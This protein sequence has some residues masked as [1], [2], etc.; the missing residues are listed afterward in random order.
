LFSSLF[1][2]EP[3]RSLHLCVN[4]LFSL[5]PLCS[6]LCDLCVTVPLRLLAFSFNFRL[7]TTLPTSDLLLPDCWSLTVDSPLT[8][9]RDLKAYPPQKSLS[10]HFSPPDAP[11]PRHLPPPTSALPPAPFPPPPSPSR[12]LFHSPAPQFP[13]PHF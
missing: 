4:F 10:S 3:R 2:C 13:L 5:C 7:S 8:P 1:L 11:P 12:A 9:P 6:Y